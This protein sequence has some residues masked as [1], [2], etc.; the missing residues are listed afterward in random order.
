ME[1]TPSWE[2]V[3]PILLRLYVSPEK[4]ARQEAF[5]Q[6]ALMAELADEYVATQKYDTVESVGDAADRVVNKLRGG[7]REKE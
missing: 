4:D 2:G 3:L 7:G 6:L 5:K 1:I